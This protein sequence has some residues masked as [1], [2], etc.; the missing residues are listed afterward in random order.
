MEGGH[1]PP[2]G[3][4]LDKIKSFLTQSLC[5]CA[6]PGALWSGPSSSR[7][8][9]HAPL[10][11]IY[12]WCVLVGQSM[13]AH[14]KAQGTRGALPRLLA[15]KSLR[16][17]HECNARHLQ[18]VLTGSCECR[19]SMG[20]QSMGILAPQQTFLTCALTH[21]CTMFRPPL[22]HSSTQP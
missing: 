19:G 12:H 22:A 7:R 16:L 8:P 11:T 10:P 2:S 4:I 20:K 15:L 21:H 18:Q 5:L 3:F 14:M 13:Q 6:A 17:L 1:Q 9:R